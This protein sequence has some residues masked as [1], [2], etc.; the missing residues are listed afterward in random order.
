MQFRKLAA[1]TGSAL[2]AGLSLAAPVLATSVTAL[3]DINKLVGITDSTVSF[4]MFVIGATAAT[5]DVA[6]AVD[7]AVNLASN[8]KTTKQVTVSGAGESVTGGV[9][10]RTVG[11][12]LTPYT[13]I[14]NIKTVITGS[15]VDILKGGS[16]YLSTG[17]SGTY[18][19]YL[20]LGGTD[21]IA[22][23]TQPQ[24][25]YDTATGETS[26]SLYLDV[27]SSNVMYEYLMTFATSLTLG[28]TDAT[29][30]TA[31]VGSTIKM[32]GKDF[33]ISD[34]TVSGG[35]VGSLTMLGGGSPLS[36]ETGGSKT[37]TF[38]GK[39][40]TITLTSVAAETISGSTYYSAIGD[41]NGESFQI[42]AG[43][44]KTLSD[45]I[46]IGATKVF[47]PIVAGQSG[48]A[49]MTI[50]GAK[51]VIGN[52]S[53]T[54]TKDGLSITGLTSN[55]T[56]TNHR[57]SSITLL[58]T[59]NTQKAYKEGQKFTD[60]FAAAF[61][62]KFN[63]L[64]P[65][66]DD[67]T[68]RQTMT[69]TSS[70]PN[71]R[72]GYTN[73]DGESET[74]DVFYNSGGTM[75]Q[76]RTSS[77]GFIT[78]E[79]NNISATQGD[80]FLVSS[81]GFSH[82]MQFNSLDS[83]NLQLSFTDVGTGQSTTISYSATASPNATLIMDGFSY[84]IQ[85]LNPVANK[86]IQV[87]LN[88]DGDI[89]GNSTASMTSA[90]INGFLGSDSS[91]FVP[92]LI[93]TGQGGLY[94]Y[95]PSA[96]NINVSTSW[97]ANRPLPNGISPIR[98]FANAT[99]GDVLVTF[100]YTDSTGTAT[101]G[102]VAVTDNSTS[103][104]NSSNFTTYEQATFNVQCVDN[105]A[106]APV[107]SPQCKALIYS[108]GGTRETG[109]GFA[110]VEEALQ[111]STAHRWVYFPVSYS[112]TL[113]KAGISTPSTNDPYLTSNWDVVSGSTTYKGMSQYGTYSEY[114]T[115]SLSATVK[116]PDSFTYANVYVLGPTGTISATGTAGSVTTETV[117][118]ITADVVKLDSEV[119]ASDK[120][121]KD[122]VLIGGPC[123]NT[124]VADLATAGKF[125]Y[126]CANW[127]GRNFGKVQ[128]IADAFATGKTVLVI[129]GTRATETDLAALM[130]QQAFNGATDTQKAGSSV[131]I[132]GTVSSPAYS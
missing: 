90:V 9:K 11:N 77:I 6:G 24:V 21:S 34:A 19:E 14:R 16:Y 83:S 126:T 123:I 20:Y 66:F 65:E 38:G 103:P 87:D 52:N 128:L 51:Y 39:D 37:M 49:T 12:E 10:V 26:P 78:D 76:G 40:Y 50:G 117:L 46:T 63:S 41:V 31:L 101:S 67:T 57:L 8:A 23:G 107:N 116:Y 102:S 115:T 4:P 68:N 55:I 74:L 129:A 100:N 86:I 79:Y 89:A 42:R 48:Y 61:D 118:P 17:T 85:I 131:E 22:S 82:L 15:D 33:A 111:G 110:L 124:L 18:K 127:P 106:A 56:S 1:I 5:S 113:V 114:D 13:N 54:V 80:Y 72:I 45:G 28:T 109:P 36:V 97:A 2:M 70:G 43:Q 125:P 93:T 29:D 99:T 120:T 119:S 81:G 35:V 94:I 44:T 105:S 108:Y 7:V 104:A 130:V 88:R 98:A 60:V 69:Y 3:K 91:F 62:L 132:T 73:L 25:K 71:V 32:L 64:T 112:S 47:A 84:G 53:A 59:P 121:S 95:N 122:L 27:P 30:Q 92:K 75:L 58:Y 96:V